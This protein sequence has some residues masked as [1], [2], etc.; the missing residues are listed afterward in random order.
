MKAFVYGGAGL[1]G[2]EDRP[3]PAIQAAGAAIVKIGKTTI[4]GTDLHILKGASRPAG[5]S[6]GMRASA[7]SM[8]WARASPQA[9]PQA[10]GHLSL[11]ARPRILDAYET[12]GSAASARALKV[13]IEA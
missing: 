2:L 9:R 11:Q 7:S 6:S 4:R 10:P 1:K 12:F 13:I 5:A 3:K 8:P